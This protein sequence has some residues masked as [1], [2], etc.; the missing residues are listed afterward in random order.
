MPSHYRWIFFF[1]IEQEIHKAGYAV[2]TLND[3]IESTPLSL[4]T[5]V[6]LVQLM[7]LI[8]VLE[9]SKGKVVYNYTDS[10]H[11]FLVLHVHANIWKERDFLIANWSP[12]KHHQEI[13]RLLFWVFLPLTVAVI[14]CKGH[15][16]WMDEIAK[17]NTLADQAAKL[18]GRIPQ[19]SDPLEASNLGGL[20]KRNK[21]SIFFW[22]NRMGHPLG[23]H[24][25]TLRMTT[26]RGWQ[27]SYSSFQSM[28]S[29]SNPSPSLPPRKGLNLS[30]RPMVV[31]R[32]GLGGTLQCTF[33]FFSSEDH[34]N[35][36]LDLL[37]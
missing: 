22:G 21:T 10:K 15:Q 36:F 12:I 8:R 34:W 29:S 16:K 35:R 11:I 28:E 26:I 24:L 5:S 27:I 18:A 37:Y 25:S 32:P 3:T 17:G 33:Y 9:L 2:V 1:N 14:H 19:I 30:I 6:Q 13:N 4:S 31:L 23:I 20:H 7:V